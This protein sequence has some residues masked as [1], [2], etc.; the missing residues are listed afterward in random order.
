MSDE[1]AK[2]TTQEQNQETKPR[3]YIPGG[4]EEEKEFGGTPAGI[5]LPREPFYPL[6]LDQ[7]LT[8]RDGET[9]EARAVRDACL[10]AFVAAVVGIIGLVVLIK[11]NA[12]ISEQK[13]AVGATTILCI[14]A[15]ATLIVAW[16]QQRNINRTRTSSAYSRLVT[17]IETRFQVPP[18]SGPASAL[19]RWFQRKPRT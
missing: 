16:I 3:G 14:G 7:F 5:P 13:V 17:T 10:G 1:I 19:R 15:V 4:V 12:P 6:R 8:L 2:K 11:W 18:A 9:S